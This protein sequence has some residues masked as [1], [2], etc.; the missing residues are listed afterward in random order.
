MGASSTVTLTAPE[1]PAL[2][3]KTLTKPPAAFF[4][5][6]TMYCLIRTFGDLVTLKVSFCGIWSLYARL[7]LC[8]SGPLSTRLMPMYACL[9]NSYIHAMYYVYVSI[10]GP[11]PA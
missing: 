1:A 4:A 11:R 5:K 10:A 7:A 2:H 9:C 3:I 8:Q 6:T